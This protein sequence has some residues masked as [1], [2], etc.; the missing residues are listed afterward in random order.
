MLDVTTQLNDG[1]R[2]LQF[3]VHKPN[4]STPLLLCHT[5]CDLL[6]AGTLVDYLTTTRQ[7][8][9]RNPY[10]VITVLIGN[11]DI[12]SPQSF[13]GSVTDSGLLKYAY[14]PPTVPI[15]LASWPTLGEMILSGKRAV[16]MLNYEADQTAIP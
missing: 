10:D 14:T 15:P 4:E 3:Q 16:I 9:D 13:V 12:L 1:I 5:S 8:L 7:W 11:F 2:M 6:N